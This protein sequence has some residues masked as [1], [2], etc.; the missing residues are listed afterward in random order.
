MK[1]V[2]VDNNYLPKNDP[3]TKEVEKILGKDEF[4][5]EL[6]GVGFYDDELPTSGFFQI[7]DYGSRD[8]LYDGINQTKEEN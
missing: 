7:V 2:W 5:V 6:F 3:L 1:R 4:N 8:M